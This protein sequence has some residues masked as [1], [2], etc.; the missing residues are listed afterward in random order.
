MRAGTLAHALGIMLDARRTLWEF[1]AMAYGC[2]SD[3]V[4][5]RLVDA[6]DVD[7]KTVQNMAKR[8]RNDACFMLLLLYRELSA[9]GVLP[10][11]QFHTQ[12]HRQ[13]M[14]E[15]SLCSL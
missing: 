4:V 11:I 14:L 6:L 8:R 1:V 15:F 7:E 13:S 2:A 3:V 10:L 12:L 5:E 9:S